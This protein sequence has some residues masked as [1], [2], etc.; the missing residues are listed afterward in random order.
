VFGEGQFAPGTR[1]GRCLIA[2]ELT[3][4][5]QQT[6]SDGNRDG[7]LGLS[8]TATVYLARQG[9]ETEATALRNVCGP[10]VTHQTI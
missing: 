7:K 3:H 9:K 1:K 5:V 8:P 2:H 4:F 6:G 10:D